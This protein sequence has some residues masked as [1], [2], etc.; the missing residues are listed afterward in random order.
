M[1]V[2]WRKRGRGKKGGKDSIF[3]RSNLPFFFV[4]KKRRKIQGRLA[5]SLSRN[6]TSTYIINHHTLAQQSKNVFFFSSP[7]P[8]LANN[9]PSPSPAPIFFPGRRRSSVIFLGRCEEEEGEKG[10]GGVALTTSGG[11]RS[12]ASS[13]SS[14]SN[15]AGGGGGGG[16][17]ATVGCFPFPL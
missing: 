14:W 6:T 1:F 2:P 16:G 10:G 7:L 3:R 11:G 4:E 12:R 5:L 17:G 8:P 13:S 15:L 9:F